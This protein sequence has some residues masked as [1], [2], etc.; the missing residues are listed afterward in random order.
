[1]P[2]GDSIRELDEQMAALVRRAVDDLRVQVRRRLEEAT[3][4]LQQRLGEMAPDLPESFISDAHIQ[5]ITEEVAGPGPEAVEEARAAGEAAGR[6]G[7][8]GA[9]RAA[10]ADLDRARSQADVLGALLSASHHYAQRVAILLLRDGKLSGWGARG[11][12][13]DDDAVRTVSLGGDQEP[14]AELAAGGPARALP[15]AGSAGLVSQL[16]SPLP[17]E[18]YAVPMVLRDRVAAVV[19]ADRTAGSGALDVD[20]VQVLTYAA[21][22]ALETLAFRE[23]EQTSTL[24]PAERPDDAED[25]TPAETAAAASAAAAVAPGRSRRRRVPSLRRDFR[26]SISVSRRPPSSSPPVPRR[27]SSPPSGSSRAPG[28]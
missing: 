4:E 16:D 20:A 9:L 5:R 14:W 13:S 17:D 15:S 7:A 23:R 11:F 21:S 3:T 12:E 25:L 2:R 1:M 18:A 28:R 26:S 6:A 19:Y 27:R 24:R 22:L 10:L 8:H